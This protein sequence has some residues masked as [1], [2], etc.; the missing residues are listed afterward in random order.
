MSL[1]KIQFLPFCDACQQGK[2][3]NLNFKNSY[4]RALE[5]LELLH[6]DLQGS[7]PLTSGNNFRYFLN[8]VDDNTRF[9]WIFPLVTKS[10]TFEVFKI[11][12][13]NVENQFGKQIKNIQTNWGGEFQNFTK[14]LQECGINH[15]LSCPHTH[16][17]NGCVERKHRHI[18]ETGLTLLAQAHMPLSFWW[19]AFQTPVFLINRLPTTILK[20][21]SPY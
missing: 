3:H 4:S 16:H 2:I 12:Q 10:Q 6:L 18:V 1:N 11:F 13:R 9:T 15:R 20:N 14:F 17:Q 21:K 19:D 5:P 7:T 8:I